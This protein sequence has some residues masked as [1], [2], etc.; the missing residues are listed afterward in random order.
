VGLKVTKTAHIHTQIGIIKHLFMETSELSTVCH[1]I[2]A[3]YA[4]WLFI[5][6]CSGTENGKRT[7]NDVSIASFRDLTGSRDVFITDL[8]VTEFATT[9]N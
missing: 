9:E 6:I 7:D 1:V 4:R 2:C 3:F 8:M 5:V